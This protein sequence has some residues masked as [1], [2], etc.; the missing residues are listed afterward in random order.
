MHRH[1]KAALTCCKCGSC[2]LIQDANPGQPFALADGAEFSTS[3]AVLATNFLKLQSDAQIKSLTKI[4]IWQT[5][6]MVVVA[7]QGM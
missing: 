1:K 5:D 6:R 7:A 2:R 4:G 3:S